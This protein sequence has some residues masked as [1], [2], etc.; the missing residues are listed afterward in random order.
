MLILFKFDGRFV[1][2][3]FERRGALGVRSLW[4]SMVISSMVL[5]SSVRRYTYACVCVCVSV[6]VC[7]CVCVCE[8]LEGTNLV[9]AKELR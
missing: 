4:G 9:L 3:E 1:S 6:M 5:M 2:W 8:G 7:V